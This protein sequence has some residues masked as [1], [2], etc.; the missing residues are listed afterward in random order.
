MGPYFRT[1]QPSRVHIIY[2]KERPAEQTPPE[3]CKSDGLMTT[4]DTVYQGSEPL[5]TMKTAASLPICG[6]NLT[7]D[8]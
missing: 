8:T 5:I 2:N 3:T 6:L 4:A 1:L 7:A